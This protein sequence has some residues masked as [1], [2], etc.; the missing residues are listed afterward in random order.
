MN[1]RSVCSNL[2]GSEEEEEWQVRED[3]LVQEEEKGILHRPLRQVTFYY[4]P[5]LFFLACSEVAAC[6]TILRSTCNANNW[7]GLNPVSFGS[8]L[9]PA[10]VLGRVSA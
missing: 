10:F 4:P 2:A 6:K 9:G 7:A 5:L 3:Y 8:N 1:Y